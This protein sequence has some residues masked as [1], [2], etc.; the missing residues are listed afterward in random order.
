MPQGAQNEGLIVHEYE[1]DV[2][3]DGG[4]QGTVELSAKAGNEPLPLGSVRKKVTAKIKTQYLSAGAATLAWGDGVAVDADHSAEVKANLTANAVFADDS[5]RA[6]SS[7]LLSQVTL[8]I[9]DAD[10]T[11]G[12]LGLTVEYYYP[13]S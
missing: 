13:K 12:K 2:A 11:A 10:M 6:Q 7:A 5:N 1:H 3:V 4:A 8:T 9:A